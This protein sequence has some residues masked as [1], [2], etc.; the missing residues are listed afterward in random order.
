MRVL[1]RPVTI[2]KLLIDDGHRLRFF[3]ILFGKFTP[4]D[5]RSPH[6]PKVI[7]THDGTIDFHRFVGLGHVTIGVDNVASGW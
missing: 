5:K 6:G 7:R 4:G 3:P 1:T 2:G